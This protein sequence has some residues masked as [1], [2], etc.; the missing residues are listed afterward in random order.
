MSLLI[1]HGPWIAIA[2]VT[3]VAM[4]WWAA[5][6]HGWVWHGPLYWMHHSHHSKRLGWFELNDLLAVS[7]APPSAAMIVYGLA[8]PPGWLTTVS[9]GVGAGMAAFGFAYAVVHDGY[10]HKRLPVGFLGYLPGMDAI[11]RAH[12]R[13]HGR[14]RVPYGLFLGPREERRASRR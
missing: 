1:E 12:L 10:I 4:E 2:V 13:H 11:R 8:A 3:A 5:W 9:L 14:G 7:H 6:V